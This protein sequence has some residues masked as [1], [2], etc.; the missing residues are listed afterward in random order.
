VRVTRAALRD[1]SPMRDRMSSRPHVHPAFGTARDHFYCS[2]RACAL[3]FLGGP[4]RR[5]RDIGAAIR[6]RQRGSSVD[7]GRAV[8]AF[9]GRNGTYR[10]EQPR[11]P[12]VAPLWKQHATTVAKRVRGRLRDVTKQNYDGPPTHHHEEPKPPPFASTSDRFRN[13]SSSA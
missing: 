8:V 1:V 5:R 7:R 13:S 9:R 12:A 2:W 6:W 10:R 4:A 11:H 3:S